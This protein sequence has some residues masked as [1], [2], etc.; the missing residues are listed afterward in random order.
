[1][2]A[3]IA[4]YLAHLAPEKEQRDFITGDDATKYFKQAHFPLP[5]APPNVTLSNAKNAGYID[6]RDRGQYHLNSIGYNLVAHKL[7]TPP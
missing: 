3:V 6:A 7:P 5:T 4:Y 2:I 1:M